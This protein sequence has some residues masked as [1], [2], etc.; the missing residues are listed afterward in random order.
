VLDPIAADASIPATPVVTYIGAATYPINQ[1]RFRSSNFSG[2]SGFSSMRWRVGEITDTNSLSYDSTKPWKYEIES[3]WESAELTA[4]NDEITIPPGAVKVGG[5]YR[6]RV[7]MTDATGRASHW[8]AAAQ[9]T[10]GE[11]DNAAA[12][13]DNLK[14]SEVMYQSSAGSE[15]D[16]VEVHNASGALTLDLN[17]V[18][19]T[20]GIDFTFPAGTTL[21]PDSYLVVVKGANLNNYAG[22]RAHYGLDSSVPIVG[23]Y[24]GDLNNDGEQLTLKTAAGGTN[25]VSFKYSSGRGWPLAAAGAGHSLVPLDSTENRQTS[26]ALEYG[27]NWRASTLIGGSPSRADP[28]P[29]TDNVALNEIVA[30]TDFTTEFDS[31]DWIELYN[32]GDTS[33]TLGENWYL[34]DSAD[35]LH[36]WMIPPSTV[37]AAKGFVSFDEVT[38][39]HN[40]TNIGFGLDKSGEQAFL[41]Y[42]PGTEEDR[43]VDA[44][45]FEGQENNWSLARFPD[46][47]PF[48]N[49]VTPRTRN[50]PNAAPPAHVVINELMYHPAPRT[51]YLEDNVADELVELFNPTLSAVN[52]YNTNGLWRLD[53]GVDFFFPPNTSISPGGYLLVVNFN[54]TNSALLS[55]FMNLYAVPSGVAIVGPYGG[56][57]G[58]D[59]DRVAL[60]KPQA[61]DLPGEPISWVIVDEVIYGDQSP[62]PPNPDGTG[63]SLHRSAP[64][65]SGNDPANWFAAPSTAGRSGSGTGD[66]DG[67]GMPDSWELANGLKPNDPSDAS[68]DPDHD[69]LTNL[70]EYVAGTDPQS[71]KN[72]LKFNS[73]TIAT[74][75]TAALRF[76]A[77]EGKSYTVQYR[78][79]LAGSDWSKLR[80]IDAQ[81]SRREE[82]ITD[83]AP[84][85]SPQR[86]YRV[87]TPRIP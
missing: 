86:F 41:S 51:G 50:A 5:T 72:V 32:R 7:R 21:S 4:F 31:N 75:G 11:Q 42:L 8:S 25:I 30:H 26:G 39:F 15:F 37:I 79:A 29:L 2:A 81:S 16:F 40:P 83:V 47:G 19:F 9:F 18:K 24:T 20:Q 23:P 45:A 78:D 43:V 38:G 61:P 77:I 57:L 14:I 82:E 27:G 64:L 48:W 49:G 76:T 71:A 84:R 52:L 36:K 67:D 69:G 56:K 34:S 60:E 13:M 35:N 46:G 6:V 65:Q 85:S 87:V 44:V 66:S 68:A 63:A 70:Q 54:P 62:W 55:D 58:N 53:G 59:S 33:I 1:L 17:G 22:F 74:D 12:L 28:S 80:D 3:S 73:V 10:V